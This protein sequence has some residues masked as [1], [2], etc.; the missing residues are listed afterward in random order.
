M[1]S[2]ADTGAGLNMGNL[3]YH[4]SVAESH[5]NLVLKFSH[6]KDLKDEDPFNIKVDYKEINK[7]NMEK[8][9]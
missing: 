2:L 7:V 1:S 6:L 5:P 4:Q 8:E 3:K 9:D